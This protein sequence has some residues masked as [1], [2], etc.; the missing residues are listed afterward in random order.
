MGVRNCEEFG[1]I[2]TR[3]AGA[4][5]KNQELCKLLYYTDNNPLSHAAVAS[6]LIFGENI[7]IIPKAAS[8]DNEKNSIILVLKR[9]DINK[10]N[11]EFMNIRL[12]VY[13]Y[14]PFTQ[15]IINDDN[16][17]PFKIIGEIQR[18]LAKKRVNGLGVIQGGDFDL[19]L[20]TSEMSCYVVEF[21]IDVFA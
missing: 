9:G 7:R 21:D 10:S 3:I 12:L 19:D 18:T 15:W 17:R 16:L 2:L 6:N 20:L 4:L 11:D 14:N 5:V 1:P 13:V 8:E